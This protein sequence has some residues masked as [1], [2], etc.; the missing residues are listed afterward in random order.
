MPIFLCSF[1]PSLNLQS[2]AFRY[3]CFLWG[4]GVGNEKMVSCVTG[5]SCFAWPQKLKSAKSKGE[6]NKIGSDALVP[7]NS[8]FFFY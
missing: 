6:G 8:K 7:L 1:N 5:H 4:Y 2:A 3:I